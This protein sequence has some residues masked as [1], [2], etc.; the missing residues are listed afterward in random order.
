MTRIQQLQS[1]GQSVWCDNL[2][3]AMLKS[4]ELRRLVELGVTGITS[5]PTIFMKAITGSSDYDDQL[6][7]IQ[8]DGLSDIDVY[9]QLAL[10]DIA[11]AADVLRSVY[12]RS[13]GDDGFVSLEVNPRLAHDAAGTMAEA[14]RLAAA[15]NR[16]N[17]M[18]K[19]P[20][21]NE[22]ISAIESLIS[23]GISVNVTLIF[24]LDMYERVMRAYLAGLQ[25]RRSSG[26]DLTTV[27]SV[28]SFFVSRVD[29]L[30]DQLLEKKRQAGHDVSELMGRAA[31]A[32]AKLAYARFESMFDASGEFGALRDK[33]A[34]VQRPLWASTSTKNP[35]YPDT[36]YVDNLIG[37]HTVNTM[38]PQTLEA[39]L[40]HART[41]VT[42]REG[43]D[44]ASRDLMK[45]ANLDIDM[46]TVTSH[47][48][49]E[50]V[51]LF[52]DSFEQLM[53]DIRK[54]RGG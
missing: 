15:L 42:I 37:P 12:D 20:A 7:S 10:R 50:G 38:P 53:A 40:D 18:I 6:E 5:N 22:G 52:A 31:M 51:Q 34:R 47:L 48:L 23:E 28:A 14:R 54:K 25:R 45:L 13:N 36:I 39:A 33:G 26:G 2:S 1:L 27:R 19:V 24:A 44:R 3:R 16:P 49:R 43:T 21:T 41:E 30:V 17:I 46:N 4:G 29:T 8:S 9:E 11:D 32:N 35:R